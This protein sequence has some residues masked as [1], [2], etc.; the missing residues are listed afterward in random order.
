MLYFLISAFFSAWL[1]IWLTGIIFRGVS[2]PN[3][4]WL[5]FFIIWIIGIV[6]SYI[7]VN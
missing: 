6:L 4:R 2:K 1:S 5:W 7:P 3:S